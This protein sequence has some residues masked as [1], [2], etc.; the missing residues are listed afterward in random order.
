MIGKRS[1]KF[2]SLVGALLVTVALFPLASI[3]PSFPGDERAL[4]ELQDLQTGWL[5]RAALA[6]DSLG[7]VPVAIGLLLGVT[8]LLVVLRRRADAT[9]MVLS[10]IPMLVGDGLKQVVERPRPDYLL[11]GHDPTSLSFPSGHSVYALLFGGILIYLSGHLIRHP[12]IRRWVQGGLCL[13]IL[14]MG[15]SRVYLGVHWPSD[16]IG[17]YL[18]G[19]VALVGLIALHKVLTDRRSLHFRGRTLSW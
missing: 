6:L 9:I 10:L 13:L 7:G 11:L 14:A 19:G 17:G 16:V 4:L 12:K 3:Y 2:Y 5:D 1:W 8:F 18:Y 15:A